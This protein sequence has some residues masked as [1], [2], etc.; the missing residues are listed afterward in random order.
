M[1]QQLADQLRDQIL[2]GHYPAGST[3]PAE[4]TIAA[5]AGLSIDAARKALQVLVHEGLITTEQG[6]HAIVRQRPERQPVSLL[7]GSHLV[8]RVPLRPER[9]Q[10]DMDLGV[11]I[12]EVRQGSEIAIFPADRFGFTVTSG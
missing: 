9:V 12:I 11:P 2:T 3:L 5:S 8:A 4:R 7:R 1:Y 10:L 6:F